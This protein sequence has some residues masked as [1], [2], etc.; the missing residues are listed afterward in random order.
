MR[1]ISLSRG[2]G[3]EGNENLKGVEFKRAWF[4][5]FLSVFPG[6]LFIISKILGDLVCLNFQKLSVVAMSRSVFLRFPVFRSS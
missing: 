2:E 3:D 1:E 5:T 6:A 4:F